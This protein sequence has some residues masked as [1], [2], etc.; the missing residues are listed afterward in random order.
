MRLN[1]GTIDF[2]IEHGRLLRRE[3]V[4]HE[5]NV[6]IVTYRFQRIARNA[7]IPIGEDAIEALEKSSVLIEIGQRLAKAA[8]KL[9]VMDDADGQVEN[10]RMITIAP[11]RRGALGQA[12]RIAGIVRIGPIVLLKQGDV[13]FLDAEEGPVHIDVGAVA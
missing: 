9:G 13:G 3:I 6:D 8:H 2:G 12:T 11:E 7:H 4:T 1:D 10:D 5:D